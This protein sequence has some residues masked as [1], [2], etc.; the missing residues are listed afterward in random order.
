MAKLQLFI[1]KPDNSLIGGFF[2][3]TLFRLFLLRHFL[4]L[5]LERRDPLFQSRYP[6]PF[7]IKSPWP[8]GGLKCLQGQANHQDG[9]DPS[10]QAN[11]G[12]PPLPAQ[13]K[14]GGNASKPK[15][16]DCRNDGNWGKHGFSSPLHRPAGGQS[17][18]PKPEVD[19]DTI[20]RDSSPPMGNHRFLAT[21]Q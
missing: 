18:L 8:A 16:S 20:N 9:G 2:A 5:R 15:E 1:E 13:A 12:I 3:S 14:P 21:R 11:R 4:K 6:R 17:S 19:A 7:A 10:Q